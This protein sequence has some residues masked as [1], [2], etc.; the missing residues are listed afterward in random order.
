MVFHYGILFSA[1]M[2]EFSQ[3]RRFEV[4]PDDDWQMDAACTASRREAGSW[5]GATP[6]AG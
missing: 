5:N 1:L 6:I 3:R 2:H 4:S